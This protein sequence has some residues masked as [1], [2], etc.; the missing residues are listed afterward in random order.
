M[1]TTD[2][3]RQKLMTELIQRSARIDLLVVKSRQA[4]A[5]MKHSYDQE[6]EDLRIKQQETTDKLHELERT[7]CNTWDN[8][9]DG[10]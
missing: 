2:E 9:G 10:G 3:Y 4:Q 8:I 5:N 6:L 7:D 1:N